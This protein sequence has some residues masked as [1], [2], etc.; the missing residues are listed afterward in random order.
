[1][2]GA[3]EDYAADH[4]CT[5]RTTGPSP[6]LVQHRLYSKSPR[7]PRNRNKA[8]LEPILST[9]LTVLFFTRIATNELSVFITVKAEDGFAFV[10]FTTI[11]WKLKNR[12]LL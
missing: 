7:N 3:Y 1:M 9:A 11:Y 10:A 4:T 12:C 2:D 5:L 8:L 6:S